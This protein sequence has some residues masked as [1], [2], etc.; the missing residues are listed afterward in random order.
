MGWGRQPIAWASVVLFV[1][2]LASP[3]ATQQLNNF[4]QPGPAPGPGQAAQPK[5]AATTN[6]QNAVAALASALISVVTPERT[7][8]ASPVSNVTLPYRPGRL[9]VKFRD[10]EGANYSQIVDTVN[11]WAGIDLIKVGVTSSCPNK[12]AEELGQHISARVSAHLLV[13]NGAAGR[14]AQHTAVPLPDS[15]SS[16]SQLMHSALGRSMKRLPILTG[17]TVADQVMAGTGIAV[18]NVTDGLSAERKASRLSSSECAGPP[19][20]CCRYGQHRLKWKQALKSCC[21]TVKQWWPGNVLTVIG[22]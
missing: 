4:A 1:A 19:S 15:Q 10:L 16:S 13:K 6:L 12:I 3:V 22:V 7:A 9:L 5:A 20:W 8:L 21:I 18:V 17:I 14:E 11:D 2:A